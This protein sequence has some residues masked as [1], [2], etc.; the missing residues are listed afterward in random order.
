MKDAQHLC[1]K[2]TAN[3]NNNEITTYL[4]ELL[5]AETLTILNANK[6]VDQ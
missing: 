2:G 4:L 1:H 3:K 5:K 6:H